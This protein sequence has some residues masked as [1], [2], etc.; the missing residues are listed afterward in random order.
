MFRRAPK[1]AGLFV[2]LNRANPLHTKAI[3][4]NDDTF[5]RDLL[6]EVIICR[7]GTFQHPMI[8]RIGD[9]GN[10][11]RKVFEPPADPLSNRVHD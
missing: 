11:A 4:A 6:A 9:D 8:A 2:A 7:I 5:G 3:E 1:A 10:A